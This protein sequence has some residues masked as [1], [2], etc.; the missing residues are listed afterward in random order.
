MDQWALRDIRLGIAMVAGMAMR[1]AAA[2]PQNVWR[3]ARHPPRDA[4]ATV[5]YAS[6]TGSRWVKP[7]KTTFLESICVS[8]WKSA[9]ASNR[10][11]VS[12]SQSHHFFKYGVRRWYQ[13]TGTRCEP[14]WQVLA[15]ATLHLLWRDVSCRIGNAPGCGCAA[16]RLARRQASPARRRC[17]SG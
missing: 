13:H 8:G 16:E 9:K 10:V 12:P 5:G 14:H 4:G 11:Q 15:S 1:L 6:Q 17:Y 7:G 3:D 2:T